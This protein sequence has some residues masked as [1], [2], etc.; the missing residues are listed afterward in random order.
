[1][2]AS[3]T[4]TTPN[5]GKAP[6]PP[7]GGS[8]GLR[9]LGV[10]RQLWSNGKA[11]LGI[12]ILVM[13]LCMAVFAPVLAPYPLSDTHFAVGQP[14]TMAHWLGTTQRGQDVMTQ[15]LYGARVSLFVGFITG[16]IAIVIA[17]L[18]GF[19]SAYYRGWLDDGLSLLI[20][21]VLVLP[22][23]P[24]MIL[25]ATY[26][27]NHGIWEIIGVMSVTGWAF[28]ARSFRAQLMTVA[29]QDY[30]MAAR[31]SGEGTFRIIFREI[32]PNMLSYIVAHF[33]GAVIGAVLGE[34]GLEFLGLGNPSITSWGTMIYWA[35]NGDAMLT[36]QWA[37][38]LAPGLCIALVATSLT[39]INFGIDAI[40]NPRLQED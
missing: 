39:L 19:V 12:I 34:A 4:I 27:P 30:V 29:Q 15:L 40:A 24:L 14:P 8:V 9:P 16:A 25:I 32:T 21:V 22:G 3:E 36:G 26:I 7:S 18:V 35:Q 23:L 11:R 17:M 13:F 37:W 1:M 2:S 20:N 33:F 5:G 6:L 10:M 31:F 28:G 38:I